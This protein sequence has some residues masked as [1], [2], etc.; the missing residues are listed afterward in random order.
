MANIYDQVSQ[1]KFRS[2][3][4]MALFVFFITLSVYLI[5]L[6]LQLDYSFTIIAFVFSLASSLISY[7]FGDQIVLSLNGA[8]PA[9]RLN[10][11]NFYTVT[12]NLSLANNTPMPKIYVINSNAPNAFAT[13]TNP[14]NASICATTGL[15]EK[16]DRTELEGVIAH[17]LSHI[18]NFDTR[19][20]TLVSVL[21]GSLSI[22]INQSQSLFY[23]KNRDRDRS[24]ILQ[25]SGL[26]LIIFA[27]I[28]G[29][30]IQLAISRQREYLADSG[31]VK[32]TRQP[33]GLI[34]A[35][36]K[37][38][39]DPNLLNSASTATASLYIINPFKNQNF[40]HLFSTHPPVEKRIQALKNLL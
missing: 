33:Q 20:M 38:S 15:L 7:F 1:N 21:I 22:L 6:T 4:L 18:K 9:D 31:A 24:S 27:P 16:L 34:S 32:L 14:K 30:I 28:I 39:N 10:Y 37:I 5:S 23:R 29:K 2:N 12:E 26:I 36:Q 35:L 17:E 25:I 11:F 13:G 3:L 40:S 8:K 19:I